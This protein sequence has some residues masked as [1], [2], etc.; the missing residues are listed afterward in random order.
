MKKFL[1]GFLLLASCSGD[2]NN[3]VLFHHYSTLCEEIRV[4]IYRQ[5]GNTLKDFYGQS[6]YSLSDPEFCVQSIELT[7]KE[8]IIEVNTVSASQYTV[9]LI[10][11]R[12]YYY[13][14]ID[15]RSDYA[16]E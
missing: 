6:G 13:F 5:D 2:T 8:T 14:L 9:K 7:V 10:L 12:N 15:D 1:L 3:G 4:I 11:D 16:R